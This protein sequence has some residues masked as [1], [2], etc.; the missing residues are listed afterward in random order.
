MVLAVAEIV[1]TLLVV[2]LS[3]GGR[4]AWHRR[5]KERKPRVPPAALRGVVVELLGALGLTIVEEE[6]RGA[7]RRLVAA[8]GPGYPEVP[9]FVVFV[10]PELPEDRV[11]RELVLELAAR[12]RA[13]GAAVGLLITPYG[14]DPEVHRTGVGVP[15]QLIDGPRLRALVARHLPERARELL[16][17][18]GFSTP[19]SYRSVP[20][21]ST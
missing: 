12:V 8:H 20:L 11:S 16:Q 10:E 3:V 19:R 13:E 7:E 2:A 14:I 1:L 6:L 4:R 9:R 18:R 21:P 15:V 5:K 17:Y